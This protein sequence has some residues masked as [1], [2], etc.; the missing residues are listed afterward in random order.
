MNDEDTNAIRDGM[1]RWEQTRKAANEAI[2][3]CRMAEEKA[4]RFEAQNDLL[5]SQNRA[6][7]EDNARLRTLVEEAKVHLS[8]F[9]TMVLNGID[10]LNLGPYRANGSID[11]ADRAGLNAVASALDDQPV[12]R[13]LQQGPVVKS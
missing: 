4:T 9:A 5:T 13:F 7:T 8:A 6:L 2:D 10:K 1:L 12:P 3:R 11:A